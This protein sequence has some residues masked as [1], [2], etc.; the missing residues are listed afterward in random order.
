MQEEP[1]RDRTGQ[2]TQYSITAGWS[3]QHDEGRSKLCFC[4]LGDDLVTASQDDTSIKYKSKSKT[5]TAAKARE[6]ALG[7]EARMMSGSVRSSAGLVWRHQR[8]LWWIFA[9]NAALAWLGSLPVRATLS[10]VLDRSLESNKLVTGFDVSTL[11]LLL[12]R[13]EVQMPALV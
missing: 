12:E 8:L 9:M 10:A 3:G 1:V 6:E 5:R 11:V 4:Q 2:P 13:P 7:R